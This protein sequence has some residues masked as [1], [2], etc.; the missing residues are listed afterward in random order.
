MQKRKLKQDKIQKANL[1]VYVRTQI[2]EKQSKALRIYYKVIS[3][4]IVKYVK[5][6]S[7]KLY[8]KLNKTELLRQYSNFLTVLLFHISFLK[9]PNCNLPGCK[10]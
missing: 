2:P 8:S 10:Y 7:I 4:N 1:S 6:Y 5:Y 3:K 9:Y